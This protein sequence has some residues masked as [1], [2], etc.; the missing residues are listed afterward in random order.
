MTDY[1]RNVGG[2]EKKASMPQWG[3]GENRKKQVCHNGESRG[4]GF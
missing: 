1:I 3:V 4:L 2:M